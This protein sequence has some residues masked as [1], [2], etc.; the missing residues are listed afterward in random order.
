M[1]Y[2]S[3][4]PICLRKL[5]NPVIDHNH[6]NGKTRGLICNHCNVSLNVIEN[7]ETLRRALNYL[8]EYVTI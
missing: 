3:D 2:K 5:D 7:P 8:K 4:C 6:K 1:P